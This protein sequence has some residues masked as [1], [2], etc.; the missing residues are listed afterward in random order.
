MKQVQDNG[1][2][3]GLYKFVFFVCRNYKEPL[4]RN[5]CVCARGF[6]GVN[7][8]NPATFSV[9]VYSDGQQGRVSW[10]PFGQD[11]HLKVGDACVFELMKKGCEVPT[12]KVHIFRAEDAN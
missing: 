9:D 7:L 10:K 6:R 5:V 12:F 3:T 1:S 4:L 2:G 8:Q 11:N